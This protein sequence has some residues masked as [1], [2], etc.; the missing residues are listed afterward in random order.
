MSAPFASGARVVVTTGAPMYV[1]HRA[2]VLFVRD[3]DGQ[4]I[5]RCDDGMELALPPDGLRLARP[6]EPGDRVLMASTEY[7]VAKGTGGEATKVY[8]RGDIGVQWDAGWEA[9][10][11]PSALTVIMETPAETVARLMAVAESRRAG[12][13][14]AS[15]EFRRVADRM[16]R[17]GSPVAPYTPAAPPDADDPDD[18]HA[19]VSP[20]LRDLVRSQSL[21]MASAET[22]LGVATAAWGIACAASGDALLGAVKR[23]LREVAGDLVDLFDGLD[24]DTLAKRVFGAVATPPASETV[25]VGVMVDGALPNNPVTLRCSEAAAVGCEADG[26]NRGRSAT[27]G[28]ARR[29]A[30]SSRSEVTT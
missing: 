17:F 8:E 20:A 22:R 4:V 5:V 27:G 12:A 10:Y 25:T 14:S 30:R 15:E 21:A 28:H 6:I 23:S 26:R 24:V 9:E 11:P 13:A 2:S 29:A 1:G 19:P 3:D 18:L 16:G 7:A